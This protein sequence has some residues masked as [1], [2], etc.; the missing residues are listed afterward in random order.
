MERSDK[1]FSL[2][3]L[4]TAAFC[5]IHGLKFSLTIKGN[6]VFFLF[7]TSPK[8]YRILQA[9]NEGCP[10]DVAEFSREIK[11][12]RAIMYERKSHD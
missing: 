8:L 11:R 6:K 9:F 2:S 5:S 1:L 7:D 12:L 3:D 4:Y 10:V